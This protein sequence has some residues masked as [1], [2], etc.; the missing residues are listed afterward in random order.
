[1]V[2]DYSESVSLSVVEGSEEQGCRSNEGGF[3]RPAARYAQPDKT[4]Y[5]PQTQDKKSNDIHRLLLDFFEVILHLNNEL[6][7]RE[8]IGF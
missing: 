1:M 3:N 2:K 5:K 8:I 7:D 6:L 4:N